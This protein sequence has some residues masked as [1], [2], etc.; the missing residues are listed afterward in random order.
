MSSLREGVLDPPLSCWLQP[1]V[2]CPSP[3]CDLL[4]TPLRALPDVPL[5]SLQSIIP[6]MKFLE[7]ELQYLNEHLVQ[8]NF[9]R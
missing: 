3:H 2:L 5:L 9:K 8:E 1:T 7:S 4:D 6:L